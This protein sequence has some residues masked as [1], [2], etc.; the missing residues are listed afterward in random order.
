M[1]RPFDSAQDV[2]RAE[3]RQAG[4]RLT[5]FFVYGMT[6]TRITS[7]AW[8]A[9]SKALPRTYTSVPVV[10]FTVLT[11]PWLSAMFTSSPILTALAATQ[12]EMPTRRQL[13]AR[14][15]AELGMEFAGQAVPLVIWYWPPE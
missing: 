1:C 13:T 15:F 3:P 7:L 5:P 9:E 11:R 4:A 2:R 6:R 12:R 8:P 14:P 10:S